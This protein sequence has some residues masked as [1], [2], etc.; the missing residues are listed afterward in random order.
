MIQFSKIKFPPIKYKPLAQKPEELIYKSGLRF[1]YGPKA[2]FFFMLRTKEPK[3]HSYMIVSPQ[4]IERDGK[5]N[6]PSLYIWKIFSNPMKN[7]FGTKMLNFARYYSE[8]KGFK[9]YFHLEAS[10]IY[11]PQSVPHIFYGKSGM[12][13]K[14]PKLNKKIEIFIK[15]KKQATQEDFP[16]IVMYYPPIKYETILEKIKKFFSNLVK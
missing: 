6:V 3:K 7:G 4:E 13:T 5:T 12:N 2:D 1:G 15:N 16:N 8:K 9:G 14:S 11:T 10:P